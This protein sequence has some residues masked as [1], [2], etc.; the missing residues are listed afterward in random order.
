MKQDEVA[1]SMFIVLNGCIEVFTEL[2]GQ[3]FVI[4]RLYRGSVINHRSFLMQDNIDSNAVCQM[5]STLLELDYE[6]LG[7]LREKNDAFDKVIEQIETELIEM[8]DNA[9]A[10]DYII[11][12]NPAR[13]NPRP[14]DEEKRRNALT[15]SLK[16]A[17][18]RHVVMNKDKHKEPKLKDIL[19]IGV[20]MMKEQ[21]KQKKHKKK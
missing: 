12:R 3:N 6:T 7:K 21:E 4:E 16:N 13:K 15:V 18:M 19:R 5:Q 1:K 2:D 17:V 9:I 14:F 10:L 8:G 20:K 11:R